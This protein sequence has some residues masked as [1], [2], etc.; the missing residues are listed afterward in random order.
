MAG[1]NELV[2]RGEA[3]T[4]AVNALRSPSRAAVFF[5]A[6]PGIGKSV[7]MD[8]VARQLAAEMT[9]VRLHGSPSL[10]NV[11]YGVLAPYLEELPVEDASHPVAVLRAIWA[12][13]ERQ[14]EEEQRPLLLM[15]D[16][17][18]DL[19]DASATVIVELV[20]ANWAKFL[21]ASRSRPGVPQPLTQLWY[22]GLAERIDLQPL[23]SEQ[24]QTLIEAVL[25]G[26]I[27]PSTCEL[28][29]SSTG[30]NPLHLHCLLEEARAAGTLIKRNGVWLLT[31]PVG[32]PGAG[33]SDILKN[34]LL[35]RPP[36]EREALNLIALA[37]PAPRAL[38]E[39]VVGAGVV[40]SMLDNQLI[41]ASP[42]PQSVLRPRHPIY[43]EALRR[44]VSASRSLQL[45]QR[46]LTRLDSEPVS[47]E[48]LLRL[49]SWSLDCG[50]EVADEQLMKAAFLASKLFQNELAQRAAA[51]IVDPRLQIPARAVRARAHYNVG[52][53]V[54][55]AQLLEKDFAAGSELPD[56]M[57]GSLLW[58]ATRSALGH[59]PQQISADAAEL[60]R[61]GERIAAAHPADAATILAG[62]RHRS[63]LLELMALSLAG[64]YANLVKALDDMEPQPGSVDIRP[65]QTRVFAMVMRAEQKMA[66]GSFGKARDLAQRAM[67]L[68]ADEEDE[69]F[70]FSEFVLVRFLTAAISA[71]DWNAAQR[72]LSRYSASSSNGLISF[73]GGV[74]SAKGLIL[75]RQGKTAQA[76]R[77]LVPAVEALRL[78]DSMQLFPV[79]TA[80][81]FYAAAVEGDRPLAWRLLDDFR[82][83]GNLGARFAQSYAS[84]YS[85]AGLECLYRDGAGLAELRRQAQEASDRGMAGLQFNALS[86]CLELGSRKEAAAVQEL[87]PLIESPWAAAWGLYASALHDGGAGDY[88]E[89]GLALHAVSMIRAARECFVAAADLFEQSGDVHGAAAAHAHSERCA[90]ELGSRVVPK[91]AEKGAPPP[92]TKLTRRERDIVAM[93]AEGLSDRQIADR[94]MVSIRTVE[95]HL[96][97]SYVKLGVRRREGLREAVNLSE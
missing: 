83:S 12:R 59:S 26:M 7:L 61:A 84:A 67:D 78:N 16:D 92:A 60:R 43:G 81:A 19:D 96:Y 57:V 72:A 31:G 87:A 13:F 45:R 15:V 51:A 94:L 28:I 1:D 82:Q 53:Y 63:Q 56:V 73:G 24:T 21:G 23:T 36:A 3:L 37:E 8:A 2:G 27:L 52:N 22:E 46:L 20:S 47:A 11:P 80:M 14:R 55:A 86:L 54:Q 93:A 29:W 95:G 6:D 76:L 34:Q 25:D 64:D 42:G 75:L 91:A 71:A 66:A 50:M 68:L 77:I 48:G 97:R 69:L 74:H 17:A 4:A 30:G 35:R 9:I 70:F 79:T 85:A 41:T 58:A 38:I 44:L 32:N 39:D 33:L 18:H 65:L 5:V 62:T 90:S 88:L 40:R 89:A 49:V 10:A